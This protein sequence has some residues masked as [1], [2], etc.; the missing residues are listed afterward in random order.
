MISTHTLQ[1]I[2]KN[3]PQ[4][5]PI[6]MAI[7]NV[8]PDSFSDGGSLTHTDALLKHA[9][10]LISTGAQILDIGG[11]STRPGADIVDIDTEKSRVLTA[12]KALREYFPEAYLSIDTR[13]AAVA[14]AALEAGA[15]MVNDVSGFQYDP[16]MPQHVADTG[17]DLILM[18]SQGTPKTMQH[19]PTYD[20][21]G[22]VSAVTSFFASQLKLAEDAGIQANCIALDVGFGFGKT[23]AQNQT[24]LDN[25]AAIQNQTY[26][27]N[28]Q[29]IS[30]PLLAG[31]S[32]KSFLA[33]QAGIFE[34]SYPHDHKTLD[35][36]SQQAEKTAFTQGVRLF[37]VH[38]IPTEA[39]GV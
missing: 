26:D 39:R 12:I 36:L 20:E 3:T 11:E 5:T 2:L 23:V 19:Q 38:Q 1:S 13:K 15:T 17:C 6:Y 16:Q 30:F 9:E 24:L 8:T 25:L 34:T 28:G 18:H 35:A 22:V 10:R 32:R 31:L 21:C 33:K 37:R 14:K 4:N 7:L 29:R 27:Y